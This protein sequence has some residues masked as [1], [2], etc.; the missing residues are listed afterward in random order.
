[1]RLASAVGGSRV[2]GP[3]VWRPRRDSHGMLDTRRGW[4]KQES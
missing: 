4:E 3:G 2:P 1:M